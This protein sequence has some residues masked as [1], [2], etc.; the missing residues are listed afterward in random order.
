MSFPK[1]IFFRNIFNKKKHQDNDEHLLV[2][3]STY[4]N[5]NFH[6]ESMPNNNESR[7]TL[8]GF[9][10]IIEHSSIP[11]LTFNASS[12][13]FPLSTKAETLA[14]CTALANCPKH[15]TIEISPF[16]NAVLVSLTPSAPH[17]C[18]QDVL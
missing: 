1:S 14:I 7:S 17:K 3:F 6:S 16:H 5:L 12:R 15:S 11:T 18:L 8:M 13:Y 9:D 4:Q 10:W 2:T